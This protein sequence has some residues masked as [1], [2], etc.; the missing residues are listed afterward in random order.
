MR[1]RAYAQAFHY[2]QEA[3]NFMDSYPHFIGNTF[4]P[5]GSGGGGSSASGAGANGQLAYLLS[6]IYI[7][8]GFC[9]FFM[10]KKRQQQT[11][12]YKYR[13]SS[14]SSSSSLNQN[15]NEVQNPMSTIATCSSK[16]IILPTN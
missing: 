5:N 1:Q 11:S 9:V 4:G 16:R 15:R 14:S 12:L 6:D 8:M 10:M 3:L 13:S 2:Y 7:G